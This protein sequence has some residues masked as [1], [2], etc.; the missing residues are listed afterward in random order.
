[1]NVIN[2]S[3]LFNY[4]DQSESSN[5]SVLTGEQENIPMLVEIPR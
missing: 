5:D 2:K 3:D 1:M 4:V